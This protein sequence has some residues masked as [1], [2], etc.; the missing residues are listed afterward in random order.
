[1][2]NGE[3]HRLYYTEYES[4]AV[5][6]PACLPHQLLCSSH[7]QLNAPKHANSL[8]RSKIKLAS[9]RPSRARERGSSQ[10]ISRALYCLSSV[11]CLTNGSTHSRCC[12]LRPP[13]CSCLG[14]CRWRSFSPG[15]AVQD[16]V[17]FGLELQLTRDALAQQL[18]Q[19]LDAALVGASSNASRMLRP[20]AR[21]RVRSSAPW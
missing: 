5:A 10:S 11:N 7:V 15:C 16:R 6:C 14:W 21:W 8:S 1:M 4:I 9:S 12:Y 2:Q 18:L 20:C 3:C 17:Q 19:V 13:C